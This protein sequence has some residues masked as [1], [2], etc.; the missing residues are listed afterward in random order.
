MS[1]LPIYRAKKLDSDEY[2][3]GFYVDTVEFLGKILKNKNG[4]ISRDGQ[5]A[6]IDKSTLSIHFPDMIDSK[7][8]KIFASLCKDDKGGDVLFDT[9]YEYTLSFDGLKFKLQ[10][11]FSQSS[12]NEFDSW[13]DFDIIGVE[14]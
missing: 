7:G 2:V 1:N 5:W 11:L 4:F 10:G 8:K 13:E 14:E 12:F 9:E 6:V 3:E